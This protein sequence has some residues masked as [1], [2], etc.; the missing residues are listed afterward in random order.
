MPSANLFAINRIKW[1]FCIVTIKNYKVKRAVIY[2]IFICT[3]FVSACSTDLDVIGDYKETLVV[4]G[5]LDQAQD[6]QYVKIN[7]AFLGAGNAFEYAQIKDSTQF[8]KALDVKITRVP[9]TGASTTYTLTPAN[10]M[11]K[12]A[13]IFYSTDQTNVIYKMVTDGSSG[14]PKLDPNSNYELNVTNGET[15]TSVSSKTLIVS[16]ITGFTK[17]NPLGSA[18]S[19]VINGPYPNYKFNVEWSSAKNARE[20]QVILRLNY[21]DSTTTGNVAKSID[22][23]LPEMKT[24]GLGGG[25][26][27]L[28]DMNGSDFYKFIGQNLSN[29][30]GL[31]AR[32][33]GNVDIILVSGSDDFATFIDVNKPSTGIIQERPEFTNI[34]NGLGLFSSRLIRAPFSRP[35]D[36][37]S[38]DSLAGGQYTCTLKFLD[39]SGVLTGC[40]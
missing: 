31:I 22:Y 3:L 36:N 32:K 30:S 28:K 19:F 5:L 17:P 15:G 27:F 4:Y 11:P 33:Q 23:N 8:Q 39:K 10:Y 18:F 40:H 20:Y 14:H 25:E 16:D 26:T 2:S 1:Y 7:K 29:Y 12:D 24:I 13:G 9:L 38:K 34:T 21:V 35:F 37:T 6:T